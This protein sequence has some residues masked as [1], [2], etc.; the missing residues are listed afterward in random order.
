MRFYDPAQ[1]PPERLDSLE[2]FPKYDEIKG[3]QLCLTAGL[4]PSVTTVLDT[5]RSPHIE[6]WLIGQGIE[7]FQQNGGDARAAVEHL[8]LRESEH[9][10]FG[11]DCHE[12][13]EAVMLGKPMP[14]VSEEVMKHA[15][16]LI[17]WIKDNVAETLFCERT[18]ASSNVGAAGTVDMVF[19]HKNGRRVIGDLK[20]VKFSWKFPPKPDIKYKMQLSAYEGM[21]QEIRP[22][23]Y[24][25]MS[26]Y[27]ASPFGWDKK[28]ELRTF[29]HG[30]CYLDAFKAARI[31]WE[32]TL[33]QEMPKAMDGNTLHATFDPGQYRKSK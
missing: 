23:D 33:L 26:F 16:P 7:E 3:A 8:Y 30:K 5:V 10:Q 1:D 17:G 2:L 19:V 22:D 11:T 28:P 6:K 9:A 24:T 25:R 20:V 13:M 27:L 31:L 29:E 32:E 18:M 12:V 21:I 4:L 14:D 15:A